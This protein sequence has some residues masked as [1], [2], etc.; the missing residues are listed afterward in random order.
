MMW[1]HTSRLSA[2]GQLAVIRLCSSATN[3]LGSRRIPVSASTSSMRL[4]RR[5]ASSPATHEGESDSAVIPAAQAEA[6]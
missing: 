4:G 2:H 1:A 3:F 6:L 5:P